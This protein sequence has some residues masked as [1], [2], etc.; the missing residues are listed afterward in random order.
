MS[1]GDDPA[2]F[3]YLWVQ[4]TWSGAWGG[5]PSAGMQA[6]YRRHSVGQEVLRPRGKIHRL[7]SIAAPRALLNPN[8]ITRLAGPAGSRALRPHVLA[9]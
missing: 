2:H 1:R 9:I 6:D 7:F 8:S 3:Y 5:N 4:D